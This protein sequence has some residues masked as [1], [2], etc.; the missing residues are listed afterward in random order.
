[1]FGIHG[2]FFILPTPCHLPPSLLPS[3]SS[4]PLI[5]SLQLGEAGSE[6]KVQVCLL[7]HESLRGN[8]PPPT[9]CKYVVTLIKRSSTSQLSFLVC[10]CV[11]GS[12]VTS[13]AA[14]ET[15]H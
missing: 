14:A 12:M 6:S 9:V 4:L 11:C 7:A 3:L 8:F 5:F 1:M 2:V 13:G 10:V 15:W